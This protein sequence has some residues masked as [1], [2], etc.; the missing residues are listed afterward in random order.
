MIDSLND[1][2]PV[3]LVGASTRAMAFSAIRSGFRPICCDR[4]ADADL[5]A[6]AE[7]HRVTEWP[8]GL[9]KVLDRYPDVP[10]M[11]GG[12]LEN[13][14]E[15]LER[16]ADSHPL[17]G[18][19]AGPLAAV[20]DPF[21]LASELTRVRVNMPEVRDPSSPPEP[22]GTWLLKPLAGSCGRGITIWNDQAA[23][24][25]TLDEPHYFQRRVDGAACSALFIA[26]P[27]RSDVRFVGIT[28]QLIG[29]S[30]LHAPPFAWCGSIGPMVLPVGNEHLIRRMGNFL[31]WS[32]EL[33]GLFG[34]D[35]ILD[36]QDNIWPTEVNPRYTGSAEI[37]ELSCGLHLIHDHACQFDPDLAARRE[38]LLPIESPADQNPVLGKAVLY[39]DRR[40]TIAAGQSWD[41][42]PPAMSLPAIADIPTEQQVI[43]P[44]EPIC[45]LMQAG[46]TQADCES[47]L[48]AAAAAMQDELRASPP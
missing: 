40:F 5:Q 21:R 28:R 23:S 12:A 32:F 11:Y 34:I 48:Q 9:P 16:I 31:S 29:T 44:G 14:P 47:R 2:P 37:L 6:V 27:D 25:A 42:S 41:C 8:D 39:S 7:T 24:A 15:L 4:F 13:A 1:S 22:D 26:P 18:V 43:G 20:R 19:H 10:V 17:W 33:C 46:Q 30:Q 35:F 45:T 38:S 36:S 3:L